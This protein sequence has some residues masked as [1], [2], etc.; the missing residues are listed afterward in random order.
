MLDWI[1]DGQEVPQACKPGQS[2]TLGLNATCE[3]IRVADLMLS[4]TTSFDGVLG[5]FQWR[6]V[7][8]LAVLCEPGSVC[9]GFSCEAVYPPV[10]NIST[11][12]YG[13]HTS[14]Y[15]E[16][17]WDIFVEAQQRLAEFAAAHHRYHWNEI[18]LTPNE[19]VFSPNETAGALANETAGAFASSV[20]W[21]TDGEGDSESSEHDV[22][23]R[24]TAEMTASRL[25]GDLPIL[26]VASRDDE[27]F[28]CG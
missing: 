4:N 23:A 21:I 7:S 10:D 6:P 2:C 26:R 5:R 1:P 27:P 12:G 20:F 14:C 15:G 8:S 22:K 9:A 3:A 24:A 18:V 16:E 11:V 19:L 13:A 28:S 25:G 17:T